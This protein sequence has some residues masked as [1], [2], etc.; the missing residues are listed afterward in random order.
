MK[1][2][3]ISAGPIVVSLA[4]LPRPGERRSGQHDDSHAVFPLVDRI[5]CGFGHGQLQIPLDDR[6]EHGIPDGDR[7][8]RA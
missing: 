5:Q 1:Q 8:G 6:Q 2:Q 3:G 7:I 4:P